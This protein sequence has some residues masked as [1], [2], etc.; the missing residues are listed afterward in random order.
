M[1]RMAKFVGSK[2]I[3][4]A[5]LEVLKSLLLS[6][7]TSIHNLIL[8]P[9]Q[10]FTRLRQVFPDCRFLFVGDNGQG[11]IDLG[12]VLLRSPQLYNVSAVLIHD[13][14]RNHVSDPPSSCPTSSNIKAATVSAVPLS[15]SQSYRWRECDRNGIYLFRTYIGA[16]FQL[17]VS[18]TMSIAAVVRVV[19]QTVQ[20]YEA[21]VFDSPEQ[22]QSLALEIMADVRQLM[23]E[24]PSQDALVLASSLPDALLSAQTPERGSDTTDDDIV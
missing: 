22:Q 18:N 2:R 3:A 20:V 11:D 12:K 14:I 8:F 9:C 23:D 16:A 7:C 15:K 19:Q 13:V 21:I 5:K 4:S 24:L 1:G 10:N 17:Y 6:R